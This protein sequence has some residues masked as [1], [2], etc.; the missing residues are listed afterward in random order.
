MHIHKTEII[1]PIFDDKL[2]HLTA[3]RFLFIEITFL[4]ERM[5]YVV[6]VVESVVNNLPILFRAN[7]CCSCYMYD[8][9]Q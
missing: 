6:S 9:L 7:E 5:Y 2:S 3:Y 8:D 4:P 1:L